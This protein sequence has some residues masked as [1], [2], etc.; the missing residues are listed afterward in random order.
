L[1]SLGNR[2]DQALGLWLHTTLAVDEEAI[3]ARIMRGQGRATWLMWGPG[4]N[5]YNAAMD[6]RPKVDLAKAKTLLAEAGYPNGFEVTLDCPNDRYI[7]GEQICVALSAMWA[8]IG[9]KVNVFARTKVRFFAD[10]AITN[11]AEVAH[12]DTLM[13]AAVLHL[14]VVADLGARPDVAASPE[15]AVRPDRRAGGTGALTRAAG[16]AGG[17]ARKSRGV[18]PNRSLN[19]RVAWA[20]SAK[21][22]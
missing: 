17:L 5:G 14:G 1:G 21:P 3:V 10:I 13:Q 12:L 19:V 11:V 22:H 20:A 18:A 9:V 15:V 4:V 8:R 7:A 16:I 2:E 6:V